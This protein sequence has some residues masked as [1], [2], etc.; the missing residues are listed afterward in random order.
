MSVCVVSEL[1]FFHFFSSKS[2]M[3]NLY[4]GVPFAMNLFTVALLVAICASRPVRHEV[5]TER[6]EGRQAAGA[7]GWA[8]LFDG[9][10]AGDEWMWRWRVFS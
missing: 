9:C 1:R 8:A 2:A 10:S 5:F 7:S 6:H 3:Q 4:A